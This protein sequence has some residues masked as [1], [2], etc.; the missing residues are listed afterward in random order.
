MERRK[1]LAL[2]SNYSTPANNK[3]DPNDKV[4][5]SEMK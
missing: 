5:F 2:N 1:N 3:K 4:L